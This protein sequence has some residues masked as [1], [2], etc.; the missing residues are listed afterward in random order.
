MLTTGEVAARVGRSPATVTAWARKGLIPSVRY[1]TGSL[2]FP[3][4]ELDA[5]QDRLRKASA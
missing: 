2:G 5:W 4:D 1:P 3:E